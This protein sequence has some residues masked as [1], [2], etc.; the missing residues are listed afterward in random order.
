MIQEMPIFFDPDGKLHPG[1]RFEEVHCAGLF[2][3]LD[4]DNPEAWDCDERLRLTHGEILKEGGIAPFISLT[5]MIDGNLIGTYYVA[6]S[7]YYVRKD[8]LVI[9][10]E[11]LDRYSRERWNRPFEAEPDPEV[12]IVLM[13]DQAT[14]VTKKQQSIK[15]L[16]Q[17]ESKDLI[18]LLVK[19]A[20]ME[21]LREKN[22]VKPYYKEVITRLGDFSSNEEQ[23]SS[24]IEMVSEKKGIIPKYD[25]GKNI[26]VKTI[27]NWLTDIR[28]NRT[29]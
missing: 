28:N 9:Q 21:L 22:G 15:D 24:L 18:K 11:E 2:Q 17:N 8:E 25:Q 6:E 19:R 10:T 27:I 12:E 5:K 4:A 14:T 7:D 13:A 26:K 1:E 16:P 20:Y 29:G 3:I 23:A